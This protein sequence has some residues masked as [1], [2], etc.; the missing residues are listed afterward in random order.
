MTSPTMVDSATQNPKT[1]IEPPLGLR[2]L[3]IKP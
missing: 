1:S 3:D 2:R